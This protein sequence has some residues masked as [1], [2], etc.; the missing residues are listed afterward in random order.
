MMY[1]Y[2]HP[3]YYLA[4]PPPPRRL[5]CPLK[6]EIA[7]SPAHPEC[8][9]TMSLSC[10]I[11]QRRYS[12][13]TVAEFCRKSVAIYIIPNGFS[14]FWDVIP[15]CA[16]APRV[17]SSSCLA[18]ASL[19]L[20]VSLDGADVPEDESLSKVPTYSVW[21]ELTTPAT[22]ADNSS[23]ADWRK[24]SHQS[25]GSD[26]RSHGH[27]QSRRLCQCKM[28]VNEEVDRNSITS[29]SSS[30]RFKSLE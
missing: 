11:T 17:V 3:Q 30:T 26:L 9:S 1:Q 22:T 12:D 2:P 21:L 20:L 13:T 16:V 5:I 29:V 24:G 19:G 7:D 18:T 27:A 14:N 23:S 25:N 8:N 15:T 4:Q 28:F 10:L 6:L